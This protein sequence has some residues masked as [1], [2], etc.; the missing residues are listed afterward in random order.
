[1]P[2]DICNVTLSLWRKAPQD[3]CNIITKSQ[4]FHF[5]LD[6]SHNISHFTYPLTYF[7]DSSKKVSLL[8]KEKEREREKKKKKKKLYNLNSLGDCRE[9]WRFV[10]S[11]NN[12]GLGAERVNTDQHTKFKQRGCNKTNDLTYHQVSIPIKELYASMYC[13]LS[14]GKSIIKY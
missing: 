10:G 6:I 11:N 9:A 2:Q 12:I 4:N 14:C 13:I 3:V 8:R 5:S 1:M 7:H